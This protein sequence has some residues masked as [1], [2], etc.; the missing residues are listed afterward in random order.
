MYYYEDKKHYYPN[1]QFL[2]KWLFG[3]IYVL[4]SKRFDSENKEETK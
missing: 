4:I 3:F 2:I 1:I